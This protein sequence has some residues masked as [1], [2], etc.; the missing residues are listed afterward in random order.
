MNWRLFPVLM[1]FNFLLSGFGIAQPDLQPF[2][3]DSS[4]YSGFGDSIAYY[5]SDDALYFW[6]EKEAYTLEDIL[7]EKAQS[8]FEA[9]STEVANRFSQGV[10]WIRF[11]LKNA[12]PYSIRFMVYVPGD[13]LHLYELSGS[14]PV[15]EKT[16]GSAMP[17]DQWDAMKGKPPLFDPYGFLITMAPGEQKDFLLKSGPHYL[18]VLDP[19]EVLFY[20]EDAYRTEVIE[21]GYPR[22]IFQAIVSGMLLM[23]VLFSLFTYFYNRD[24]TYLFYAL[25]I[26]AIGFYLL[27]PFQLDR[28]WVLGTGNPLNLV[29]NN[30]SV[31]GLCLGYGFYVWHF[32]GYDQWPP[33]VLIILKGFLWLA[34]ISALVSTIVIVLYGAPDSNIYTWMQ[35]LFMPTGIVGSLIFLFLNVY[36]WRLRTLPARY[37]ALA[38]FVILTG[39]VMIFLQ[40]Q[41]IGLNLGPSWFIEKVAAIPAFFIVQGA[42]V[43]QILLFAVAL[44]LRT[45]EIEKAKTAL[46]EINSTKSR[47]FANISHEFKTPLTLILGPVNDLIRKET[48]SDDRGLLQL[49]QKNAQKLLFRINEILDLAKLESGKM[50]IQLQKEDLVAF[51]NRTTVQF[52]SLAERKGQQLSFEPEQLEELPMQIDQDMIEKVIS[53]LVSNAIRYTPEGGNILVKLSREERSGR[54]MAKIEVHDSGIGMK[55]DQLKRVFDRFYRAE[56]R[57]YTM[58]TSGTGIGLALTE[59]LVRMHN[60]V[61]EVNSEVGKGTVVRVWLPL[62]LKAPKAEAVEM[63]QTLDSE[64]LTMDPDPSMTEKMDLPR[65]LLVED[66]EELRA[67]IRSCLENEFEILEAADGKEAVNLALQEIPDLVLTD[68]MMPHKDGYEVCQELKQDERTSHIPVIILTGKSSV[69][70]RITGLEV[71]ADV[72]LSKPFVAEELRL[73]ISNQLQIRD[74]L[75]ELYGKKLYLETSQQE[76]TSM[77]EAFLQ[78]A[79]KVVEENI[80]EEQFG[81]EELSQALLMDRTQLYRKLKA[82]VGENPS[83]FIRNLRLKRAKYLLENGAGTVADIA[84]ELGFSNQSYFNKV[85]KEFYGQTPGSIRENISN[86]KG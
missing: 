65:I 12:H 38:G 49:I 48:H 2:V 55:P 35:I 53:N 77:E 46:E 51:L 52:Q 19:G 78:K 20:P 56:A 30:L 84:F 37:F 61:I 26:S 80:G 81:V 18:Q 25:Y 60:G 71:E 86:N 9:Y 8:F 45:R 7:N 66:H 3:I 15:S 69:E 73:Q 67:Y 42:T 85:F 39:L 23:F 5:I 6:D 82:L 13:R 83:S 11:R 27:I 54:L 32:I 74:R 21:V 62:D 10:T 43:L 72:Y 40:N 14:T 64:E 33:R 22:Q 59:E 70:S 57:N 44:S 28:L 4:I 24:V 1:F 29:P 36:L 41:I 76:V 16:A 68:V 31:Y 75:R 47:F 63:L 17:I 34:G 79:V 50:K 58:D